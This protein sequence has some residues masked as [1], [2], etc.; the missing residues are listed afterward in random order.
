MNAPIKVFLITPT[1]LHMRT[2]RRM[3]FNRPGTLYQTP[4]A[5]VVKMDPFRGQ[6]ALVP[7]I[8]GFNAQGHRLWWLQN[9]QVVLCLTPGQPRSGP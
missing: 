9:R 1:T 4:Q 5:L 3:F 2:L 7:A 6:E 8:D